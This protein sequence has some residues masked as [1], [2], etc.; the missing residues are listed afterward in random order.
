[1]GRGRAHGG[2]NVTGPPNQGRENGGKPPAALFA[3]GDISKRIETLADDIARA[4]GQEFVL[5]CVL[6]GAFIFTADLARSLAAR[7]C[8]PRIE[9][10]SFKSYGSS[11]ESSGR[12]QLIGE[13][14][15][16]LAGER[17]LLVD[18]ILDT[19]RTLLTARMMVEDAG[20]EKVATCVLLD[21]PA[22][23]AAPVEADH[24]GFAID[25][26]FVVGYGIDYAEEF[27]YLP[28]LAHISG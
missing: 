5:L 14:P 13:F 6:N 2:L 3:A 15:G 26:V 21:K 1:M 24:V 23:R 19:G 17:V 9:F 28:D 11:T 7:G 25:D 18:D 4:M 16:N 12:V 10:A 20:A 27:R 22:R 8:R